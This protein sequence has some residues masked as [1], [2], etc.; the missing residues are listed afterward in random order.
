MAG[1][2]L[3]LQV[4]KRREGKKREEGKLW[5]AL[6]RVILFPALG[7]NLPFSNINSGDTLI[8]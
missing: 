8:N 7:R 3:E 1:I 5:R 6:A 4:E 2:P